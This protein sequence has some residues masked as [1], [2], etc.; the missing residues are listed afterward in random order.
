V[1]AAWHRCRDAER[2]GIVLEVQNAAG[3]AAHQL[4]SARPCR[5][6]STG[7]PTAV[8]GYPGAPGGNPG[9]EGLTKIGPPRSVAGLH[10][11]L[12]RGK[13]I[14]T[15]AARGSGHELAPPPLAQNATH[16]F[17]RYAGHLRKIGLADPLV[18][19]D[20]SRGGRLSNVFAQFR[21]THGFKATLSL[22]VSRVRR[23]R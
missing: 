8:S 10:L 2:R 3:Q 9:A 18:E 13:V 17:P 15:V 5:R 1:D 22:P 19:H 7:N 23:V 12:E 6:R 20:M 14:E 21:W 16:I 11:A 4:R